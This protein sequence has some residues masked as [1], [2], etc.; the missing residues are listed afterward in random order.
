MAESRR[1][2]EEKVA[3][4]TGAARGIGRCLSLAMSAEGAFVVLADIDTESLQHT[5][6]DIEAN[7]GRCLV[8]NCD[9][10]DADQVDA[11]VAHVLAETGRIDILVNNAGYLPVGGIE[12]LDEKTMT[13]TLAINLKGVLY[14]IRAVTPTMK[15]SRYGKI[16]NVASITGKNGDNSSSPAYGAS[17]GGVIS[18]TRS[19]ARE[20]GPFGINCNAVAPHAVITDLMSYWDEERKQRAANAIPLRRL[21][22]VE[23]ISSLLMFL[24]SD[25]SSFISGET[26]NINGGFYMD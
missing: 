10:T 11:L 15:A 4:I 7:D 3:I 22:T 26:I 5:R 8:Q 19:I 20:L 6:H 1:R 13:D 23:D 17:K 16:V 12:D 18:L 9:V 24:A 2:F 25:E 14:F 21:G